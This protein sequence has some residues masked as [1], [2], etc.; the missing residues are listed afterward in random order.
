MRMRLPAA[1]ITM[2]KLISIRKLPG[3]PLKKAATFIAVLIAVKWFNPALHAP[4]LIPVPV[5]H[6]IGLVK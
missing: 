6:S 2:R 5:C 4:L 3:F 1:M